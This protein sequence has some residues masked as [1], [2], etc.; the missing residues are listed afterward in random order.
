[1]FK[2]SIRTFCNVPL[3]LQICKFTHGGIYKVVVVLLLLPIVGP[4]A[5][6]VG[7][8]CLIPSTQP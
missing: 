4:L 3:R 5:T 1:M 7:K 6:T 2:L 8:K